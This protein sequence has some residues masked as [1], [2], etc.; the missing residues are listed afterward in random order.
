MFHD[1]FRSFKLKFEDVKDKQL[2]LETFQHQKN[3]EKESV[4][5]MESI[6]QGIIILEEY[7][8]KMQRVID[9][10][11]KD[12]PEFDVDNLNNSLDKCERML[13]I[14]KRKQESYD[15]PDQEGDEG[16][17]TKKKRKPGLNDEEQQVLDGWEDEM[18]KI[19]D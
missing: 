12:L 6:Q 3:R 9:S 17:T 11:T 8:Q 18:K 13:E 2:K 19:V 5:M 16:K 1:Y 15:N 7:L 10:I 4:K 14:L